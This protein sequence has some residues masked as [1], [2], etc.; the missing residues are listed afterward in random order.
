MTG[1][2]DTL[3]PLIRHLSVRLTPVL[4]RHRAKGSFDPVG[5]SPMAKK[6]TRVSIL[7]ASATA[8]LSG[9]AGQSSDGPAG[10]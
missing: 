5:V 9:A 4:A 7:S 10:A 6:P 2:P 8:M 3:F 1:A